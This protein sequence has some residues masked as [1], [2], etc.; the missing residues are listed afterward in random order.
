MTNMNTR[1]QPL[2]AKVSPDTIKKL[3]VEATRQGVTRST[4]V[5]T[6]LD[7]VVANLKTEGVKMN[8]QK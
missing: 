6:L 8:D 2:T 7:N 3:D 4:L 1:K 5:A